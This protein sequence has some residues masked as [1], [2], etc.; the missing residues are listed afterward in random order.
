MRKRILLYILHIILLCT[1]CFD[2]SAQLNK[3]YFFYV[4][5]NFLLEN[6]YHDAIDILNVLLKSDSTAYEAFFLRGVAKYNLDDLLGAEQD[7][8]TALQRNPVFTI[9]YQYRAITRSML[10]NYDDALKDF[11]DAINLRPDIPG[12]L[13][14]RGVTY[15]LNQQFEKAVED[16]TNFIKHEDKVAD[17]YINR[18]TAYL[19]MKDTT[20]AY[21]DYN[22]AIATNRDYAMGYDRRGSLYMAQK[23]YPEALADFNMAIEK[24]SADIGAYFNRAVVYANTNKLIEAL[25]DFDKVLTLDSTSSVTYFNRALLR[26]QIGAYNKAL[27]DYNKV[28]FFSPNNVLAY[29]NRGALLTQLGDYES[30]VAD[31]SKAIE[32]YPDFA[33]AYLRRSE[34]RYLLRD[35]QGAQDDKNIAES[36]IA[37]YRS[38]LNDSTFS[39]YADT[40]QQFNRLLSFDSKIGSNTA[41]L[42][43]IATHDADITLQPMF[44]FTFKHPENIPSI[45]LSQRYFAQEL[46]EFKRS[47]GFDYLSM[48][49][50]DTDISADSL[51]MF[52]RQF[53]D[54]VQIHNESW[55][56][57]FLKGLSQSL[58]KQYT[59]AI[60]SYTAAIDKDPTNAFLY[61]NRSTTQSE[62]IDFISSLDNGLQRISFDSDPASRLKSNT[63]RTYNYDSAIADLNA[64]AKLMPDYAVIYYNR[65]NLLCL[66]G[67]MPEAIEDYTKAIE[68]NPGFAE[69]Y[70]NR[71]LIQIYL[72]DTRKGS[73]DMSK[74]G[75]LGINTA[76]KVLK[77]YGQTGR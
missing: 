25:T 43:N 19:Y 51:I 14:S 11:E 40:S 36:K 1:A 68:L 39:I 41:N 61:I 22:K 69:A 34:L 71:G 64:A 77:L 42:N 8:T 62:M 21:E 56:S 49:N 67:F 32:L 55:Q 65:A 6:K 23:K 58:I 38:K 50:T 7:F 54:S 27:E 48:T 5:R 59:N 74:A 45:P 3:Q 26:T 66:S 10:G 18:G 33:N 44:K 63:S 15:L 13:Y 76:Y 57:L 2:A 4:S 28:T 31:Y 35:N 70:F 46:E 73:L 30:A 16:F 17:A 9:A 37:E 12:P 29:F 20:R 24:D 75:E 53:T 72:K 47:V 60:N 52:D